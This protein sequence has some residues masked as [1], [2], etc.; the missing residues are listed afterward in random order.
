MR[1]TMRQVMARWMTVTVCLA[2]LTTDAPVRALQARL[3]LASAQVVE[4]T[5]GPPTLRLAANGPIAF[6]VLPAPEHDG[7]RVRM[8][9]HGI[10][11]SD[12][13]TLG[14]LAPFSVTSAQA[15][16]YAD[17]TVTAVLEA[18]QTLVARS[19]PAPHE[20]EVVLAS[21]P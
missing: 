10:E 2:A 12:L 9:L 3:V 14:S 4:R 5:D 1:K 18:G 8:R 7:A 20:V 13:A 15:S 21:Q 17:V 16:G 11:R 19:G 6:E